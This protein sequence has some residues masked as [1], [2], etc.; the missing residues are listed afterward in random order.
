MSTLVTLDEAKLQLRVGWID[1]DEYIQ[2][3]LDMCE[4]AILDY[5][6]RDYSWTSDNVPKQVKLSI[7]VLLATYYDPYRDGDDFSNEVAM[8][9]FPPAVTSL[10]HRL[11][12][13]AYA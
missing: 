10:L 2:L 9:Y 13:P 4:A 8:G 3:L 7:L 6:K 5:I 12:S 1:E 11:R